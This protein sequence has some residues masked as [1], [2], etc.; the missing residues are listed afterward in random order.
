[1]L[2]QLGVLFRS[3]ISVS[4]GPMAGTIT[5]SFPVYLVRNTAFGNT[6]I[7]RP[8][9]LSQQFGDYNHI[10]DIKWWRDGVAPHLGKVERR[11]MQ[12][13]VFFDGR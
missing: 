6:A 5:G 2:V 13:A 7:S 4:C 3:W 8:A 1:M 10:E 12:Y 9:D 11:E